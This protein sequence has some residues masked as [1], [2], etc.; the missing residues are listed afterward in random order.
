[1]TSAAFVGHGVDGWELT[2]YEWDEETGRCRLSYTRVLRDGTTEH[3]DV[4]GQQDTY[5][6]RPLTAG[7]KT[8][9]TYSV[10]S[11]VAP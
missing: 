6:V 9:R 11:E 2:S 1:M 3:A 5:T 8:V 7:R 4:V 10:S